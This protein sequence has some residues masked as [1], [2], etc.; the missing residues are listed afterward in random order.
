MGES[1]IDFWFSKE[2]QG[3][4]RIKGKIKNVRCGEKTTQLNYVKIIG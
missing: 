3:E 2:V 1:F 4:C